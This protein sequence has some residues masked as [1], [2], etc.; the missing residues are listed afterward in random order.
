MNCEEVS[1][2]GFSE[3]PLG[4]WEKKSNESLIFKLGMDTF[5]GTISG[6]SFL[7]V[8]GVSWVR[9]SLQRQRS[10]ALEMRGSLERRRSDCEEVSSAGALGRLSCEEVSSGGALVARKSRAAA[11]SGA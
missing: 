10:R 11:L 9:G 4:A 7:G 6:F 8:G 1:G 3:V 5:W 2:G